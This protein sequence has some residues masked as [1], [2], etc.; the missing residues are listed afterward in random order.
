MSYLKPGTLCVLVCGPRPNI[1]LIV[2][3]IDHIGP[4]PPR[5]DVYRIRT[6]SG[7]VFPQ[8]Y[9]LEGFPIR[10]KSPVCITDRHKLRPLV[11]PSNESEERE[12]NVGD[13]RSRK[14]ELADCPS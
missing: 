13:V 1:G 8:L 14:R 3:I 2:E 9:N 5:T 10:T 12:T 11:D 4:Y 6:V 7:R